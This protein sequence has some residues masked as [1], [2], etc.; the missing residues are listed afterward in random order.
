MDHYTYW[1]PLI[2]KELEGQ[3]DSIPPITPMVQNPADQV[4]TN[5]H[6]CSHGIQIT[7]PTLHPLTPLSIPP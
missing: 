2:V 6:T 3:Q 4:V 7:D 5:T 1:C